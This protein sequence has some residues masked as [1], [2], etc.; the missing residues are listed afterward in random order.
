MPRPKRIMSDSG[1]YHV[2]YRGNNKEYIFAN[3]KMK[4]L[5]LD[6]MLKSAEDEAIEIAVYCIMNNHIHLIVKSEF[7]ALSSFSGKLNR[8]YALRYNATYNRTGH[9][10]EDRFRSEP[11]D[12]DAYLLQATRYIHNNPVNAGIKAD[13][14]DY[15][16]SSYREYLEDDPRF[17]SAAQMKFI[18]EI[19]GTIERFED[20]HRQYDD[21]IY[22][23]TKEDQEKIKDKKIQR[24]ISEFFKSK[25]MQDHRL[26]LKSH[27]LLG[28][29][30]LILKNEGN[31][32]QTQISKILEIDPKTIR[33]ILGNNN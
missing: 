27:D 32:S 28:E 10:F 24:L 33:S 2:M 22:L 26:L 16:W 30:I 21:D 25:G 19:I 8:K 4:Q 15:K 12:D 29:L 5:F 13:P 9:A 7:E 23:D 1:Y 6:L 3:D 17:V 18:L 14:I 20:F 31:L 11:I